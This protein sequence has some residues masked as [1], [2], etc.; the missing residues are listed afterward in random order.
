MC[1][2]VGRDSLDEERYRVCVCCLMRLIKGRVQSALWFWME[3]RIDGC[4]LGD[5]VKLMRMM[6]LLLFWDLRG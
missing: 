2:R 6:R 1:V 5:R 4:V 3:C